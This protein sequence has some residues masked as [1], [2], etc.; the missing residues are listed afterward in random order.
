MKKRELRQKIAEL[1]TTIQ[2]MKE[3]MACGHDVCQY[4]G[5]CRGG[6]GA[7]EDELKSYGVRYYVET[8]W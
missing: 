7:H 8:R 2:R 6:C 4:T 1:E 3:I 5:K